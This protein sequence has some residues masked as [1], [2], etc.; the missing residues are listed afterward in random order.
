M[1]S[2]A[3]DKDTSVEQFDRD[4]INAFTKSVEFKFARMI[5]STC[6]VKDSFFKH[7]M[8]DEISLELSFNSNGFEDLEGGQIAF[9]V[10]WSVSVSGA[11]DDKEQLSEEDDEDESTSLAEFR[12]DYVLCFEHSLDDG[13]SQ[14]T[15]DF[16]LNRTVRNMSYGS[17]RQ[18]L[19]QASADTEANLPALPLM[20]SPGLS[21]SQNK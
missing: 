6:F 13:P 8:D 19:H 7:R 18:F 3:S 1:N 9:F 17:F 15:L 16:F 5:S 2:I 4:E 21:K 20:K 11:N 14:Q 10:D 12:A